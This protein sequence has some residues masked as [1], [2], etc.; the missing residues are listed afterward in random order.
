[1]R[2]IVLIAPEARGQLTSLRALGFSDYLVKPMRQSLLAE[3][4][5]NAVSDKPASLPSAIAVLPD[6]LQARRAANAGKRILLAEDNPVNAMLVRELLRRRGYIVREVVSGEAAL[7][8]LETESFDAI[9]TDIHMPGL[10]GIEMARQLRQRE[11]D[12]G[13]QRTP[14]LALTADAVETGKHACMDAGMD[15]FLTKPVDPAELETVLGRVLETDDLPPRE[16]AA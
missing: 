11:A 10:D 14:I 5:G 2:S 9:L 13:R 3:R 4:L 8:L 7:G 12:F 6:R 16:A 1:M 15:G